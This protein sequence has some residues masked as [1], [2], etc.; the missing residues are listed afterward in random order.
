VAPRGRGVVGIGWPPGPR[1]Q[2]DMWG[3]EVGGT[4]VAGWP[5]G[6]RVGPAQVGWLSVSLA[7]PVP[8]GFSAPNS[9]SGSVQPPVF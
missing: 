9:G 8:A 1:A 5:R 3:R 4:G 7:L 6:L 2:N